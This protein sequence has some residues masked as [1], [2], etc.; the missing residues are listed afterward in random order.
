MIV[1]YED[2]HLLV[3]NK[4]P[5]LATQGAGDTLETR[6]RTYLQSRADQTVYLGTVHRLDRPVSGVIAW[7]KTIKAA[8]R[9]AQQ[10]ASR[11]VRKENWALVESAPIEPRGVWR[12]WLRDDPTN[13]GGS[14]LGV[15]RDAHAKQAIT[16]YER[17]LLSSG[18]GWMV[19]RPETGRTHQLRVQCSARGMPILGDARYGSTRPFGEGIALHARRLDV[20]HPIVE[21]RLDLVAELPPSWDEWNVLQ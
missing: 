10:F 18:T 12:D 19:L 14:R 7:A 8:R 9:L 1:L 15:E 2:P 20:R 16:S 5:D 6:V 11:S 17:H 13:P 21:R 4:P 3:V